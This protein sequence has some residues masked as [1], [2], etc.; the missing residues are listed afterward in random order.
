MYLKCLNS[1][2]IRVDLLE[3][4]QLVFCTEHICLYISLDKPND[5]IILADLL[6]RTVFSKAGCIYKVILAG[7]QA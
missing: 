6:V 5:T 7:K 4:Y 3:F 2:F 1:N